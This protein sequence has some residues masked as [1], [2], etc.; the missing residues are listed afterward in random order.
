MSARW[1]SGGAG[2][3]LDWVGGASSF[4]SY[5]AE[6]GADGSSGATSGSADS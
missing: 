1:G 2:V 3:G 6:D 5:A 4:R